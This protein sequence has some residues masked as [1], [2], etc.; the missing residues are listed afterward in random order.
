MSSAWPSGFTLP[1]L[2]TLWMCLFSTG[3]SREVCV[4]GKLTQINQDL[5]S[6]GAFSSRLPSG[7]QA[8]GL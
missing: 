2:F 7:C 8:G 6:K 3:G 5:E 4:G 1:F